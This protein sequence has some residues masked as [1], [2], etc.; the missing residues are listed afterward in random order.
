[1]KSSKSQ[2]NHKSNRGHC[3]VCDQDTTFIEF[4]GW[5]RDDYLCSI[6]HCIPRNRAL[7]NALNI[8]RPG[9]ESLSLHESSP[10]EPLSYFL[11]SRCK[12]YT[13]SH[14]FQGVKPGKYHGNHRSEDLTKMTFPKNSFDLFLT[15]D[16]FEHVV[17]PEKA[18][19]EI[20]RVLKPG[21][22]HIFTIP[23]NG[24]LVHT[25]RRATVSRGVVKHLK[26]PEYHGNPIN[27]EGSL[28]VTDWGCDIGDIIYK[29]SRMLTTIYV[30]RSAGL[31]LDGE[32][33]E[34]FVTRK[35]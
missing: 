4:S 22:L 15:S 33:L 3:S 9:W 7:V 2:K 10:S 25:E 13:S 29:S 35:D 24:R 11:K 21:G 18:F 12:K 17:N 27:E 34:V 31:G 8:F 19:K 16:V 26:P 28:V 23:W 14:F 6:C 20:A 5:K 30:E 1:M 32:Y